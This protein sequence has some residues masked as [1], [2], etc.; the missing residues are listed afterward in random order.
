MNCQPRA[1]SFVKERPLA[2]RT[3]RVA[4]RHAEDTVQLLPALGMNVA[5]ALLT[6]SLIALGLFMG[7]RVA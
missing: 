7:L 5:V 4:R 3:W 1:I 2:V 6:P